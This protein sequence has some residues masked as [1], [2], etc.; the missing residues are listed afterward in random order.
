[1]GLRFW[2]ILI[3]LGAAFG[4]SF[5]FNEYLLQSYG[6]LTVSA[7]R[8]ALGALGGWVWIII[9]G[10]QVRVPITVLPN[11]GL[12]GVFQFAAPFAI[13]PLAQQHIASATAGVANALTPA[14]VLLITHIWPGGER[15]T[16]QKT[17]GAMLGIG[18]VSILMATKPTTAAGD[19]TYV[20]LAALAPICYGIALNLVRKFRGFDPVVTTTWAM[21][22]G[23]AFVLPVAFVADG[24]PQLP[25]V[26]SS[27]AFAVLSFGLT[28]AAFITMFSILPKVGSLNL[29]LTTLV[30][31]ISAIAIGVLYF[32]EQFALQQMVG[33]ALV[34]VALVV[35]DGRFV[36]ATGR[37]K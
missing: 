10:R 36:S 4:A 25:S 17:I 28:T 8:V 13:L 15:A 20:A 11:L 9:T 37:K 1:M 2:I 3:A 7:V 26:Q 24:V 23:A 19:S 12:Y 27:I 30:A 22:C 6:G 33:T 35:I 18:G 5:G 16:F 34:L 31:P 14:A 32:Q 29:S 21:T